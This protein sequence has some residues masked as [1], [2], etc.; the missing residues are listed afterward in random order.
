[1]A[2]ESALASAWAW[3]EHDADD[4]AARR[5]GEQVLVGRAHDAGGWQEFS[6]RTDDVDQAEAVV[7]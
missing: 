3:R 7:R 1:M 6:R 5:N 4:L 2:S